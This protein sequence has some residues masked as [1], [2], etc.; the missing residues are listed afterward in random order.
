LLPQFLGYTNDGVG[1]QM[2]TRLRN[3]NQEFGKP[4]TLE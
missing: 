1:W 4:P 3:H 2:S